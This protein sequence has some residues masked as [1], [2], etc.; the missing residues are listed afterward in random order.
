MK[1]RVSKRSRARRAYYKR[2]DFYI[3]YAK[4]KRKRKRKR[5]SARTLYHI[6]RTIIKHKKRTNVHVNRYQEVFYYH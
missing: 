1:G 2:K 3:F 5:K 4:G 6:H